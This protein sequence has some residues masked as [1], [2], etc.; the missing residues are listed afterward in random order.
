MNYHVIRVEFQ[1]HGSLHV[2]SFLWIIDAPV[3][4]DNSVDEYIKFTDDI[5]NTIYA[6]CKRKSRTLPSSYNK[7][8]TLSFKFTSKI[9]KMLLPI[10]KFSVDHITHGVQLQ[11]D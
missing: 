4:S 6:R 2:H 1:V 9:K 11:D 5:L 7:T 8:G 3:L 10:W